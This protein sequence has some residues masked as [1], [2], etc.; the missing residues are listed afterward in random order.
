MAQASLMINT[1]MPNTVADLGFPRGGGANIR[2]CQ[3]LSKTA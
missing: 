3:I 1:D 2:F